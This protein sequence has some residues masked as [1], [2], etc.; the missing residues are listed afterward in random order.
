MT[1]RTWWNA[2]MLSLLAATPVALAAQQ[3]PISGKVTNSLNG[4]PVSGASVSVQ[5][6]VVVAQ[7]NDKGEYALIAPDKAVTLLVRGIGYKRKAVVVP[8]GQNTMDIALEQDIF[9]LEAVVVTGQATTIE[10]RNLPNAVTTIGSQ[11]VNAAPTATIESALQGKV[12]GALIQSNSGA[13]GG[14]AQIQLRGVSTINAGSDPI[15]VVDGLIISNDA[16]ASNMNSVTNAAGG[17]NASNQDNAVNRMADLNP[18]DIENVEIMKGSSAA[19]IYGAAAANG[20]IIITTKHGSVG[21]PAFHLTQRFGAFQAA[22]LLESRVWKDSVEADAVYGSIAQNYCKPN[23]PNYNNIDNL[24]GESPLSFETDAQV[25]GGTASTRYFVS[26]LVKNDGGIAI[27][28]GYQKQAIRANLDQVL[29]AH[30]NLSVQSQLIHSTSERGISNNDNTGTSPYLVFPFT[31]S[32]FNLSPTGGLAINDYPTNPFERSNP[33]QTFAF[34]QNKEDVWRALATATLK[35][36]PIATAEHSLTFTVQGGIDNFGQRNDIYSP[37][38]LQYEPNDGQPGTV[39]LGK[40]SNTNLNLLNNLVYRYTPSSGSYVSTTSLSMVWLSKDLNTTN[41][42]GRT[43]PPLLQ[44]VDKATSITPNQFLTPEQ[45]LGWFGQEELL[46]MDQ[47]L[48]VTAGIRADRSS[49]NGDVTKYY[50]YPKAA[51][52]YRLTNMMGNAGDEVKLRLAYGQTGNSP[53]FQ[54][55][56][57]PSTTGT[58]GGIYGAFP[59]LAV[60]DPNIRPER[61]AE[62]EAG[63][64]GT[65]LHGRLS[66]NLTYY[67]RNITDLLLVQTLAP[68][69]G[70]GTRIFNGG[71]MAK[72]GFEVTL[73][74]API[75][76]ASTN[77]VVRANFYADRTKVTSLP[78]PAFEVGG[79]G[80]GLGAFQVEQGKSAT[81]IIGNVPDSACGCLKVQQVGDA[82]PNFQMSFSSDLTWKRFTLGFLFDWKDG[83]DVINLTELLF[84]AGANSFDYTTKGACGPDARDCGGA[85]RFARWA[86]QG[87]TRPYIQ[88]ASYIKM[89]ELSLTYNLPAGAFGWAFGST[90]KGA[91]LSFAG[92]NLIRIMTTGYRGIDPEVSNFGNQAIARNIDVAPFPPTRSFFFSIDLDF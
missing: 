47:R 42:V 20:V 63:V 40:A 26:G 34:L 79:F 43:L 28:T 78:V 27:N 91:R 18:A 11:S 21:A 75:Q 62:V 92:R 74:Y 58:I 65:L 45:D 69:T 46:L 24:Y 1:Q 48:N 73:G 6:S 7:T 39:V 4:Q 71:E 33:L 50:F 16:I 84:D 2:V 31:P 82:N 37:P 89:R 12:P 38:E 59:G 56:F 67:H 8:A 76:T 5:G 64:D 81:Q 55:K 29:G 9:N 52:S 66:A 41:L 68:S 32:F 57:T 72:H 17:G 61:N 51:A 49:V 54:T 23:C 88:D 22:H 3:R 87:D 53:N 13:P 14:G 85:Q 77:W 35:F 30:W 36:E 25:S 60:G 86:G 90:V 80:T 44:G 19:A 70:G 83:G 15:I 10:Q